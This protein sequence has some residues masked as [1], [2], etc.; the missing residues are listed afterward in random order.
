MKTYLVATL[1]RYV[2][3]NAENEPQAREL[4]KAA[5]QDLYA[6]IRDR[7]G[8]YV[9]IK[10]RTVREASEDEIELWTWHH[11]MLKAEAER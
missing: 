5:L 2:L 6:D 11:T 4:G 8:K 9:P 1:A 10:I 7:L 3:V